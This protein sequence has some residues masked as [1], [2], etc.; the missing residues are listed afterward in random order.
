MI[1]S[2]SSS[3]S[4]KDFER[5]HGT[6]ESIDTTTRLNQSPPTV[7]TPNRTTTTTIDTTNDD[8]F[9]TLNQT[10]FVPSKFSPS[11]NHYPSLGTIHHHN[12]HD[13]IDDDMTELDHDDY[14]MSRRMEDNEDD[15][16][17]NSSNNRVVTL[18]CGRITLPLWCTNE[19]S[20][21][22]IAHWV[23]QHAPCFWCSST[24]LCH[25]QQHHGC[26]G[27]D[28]AATSTNR[29]ILLRMNILCAVFALVQM[30]CAIWLSIVLYANGIVQR[31]SPYGSQ[32][33][34]D[35]VTPDLWNSNV[36]LFLLGFVSVAVFFTM[37]FTIPVV[38]E[39]NL[40]GAIRY[41]WTLVWILPLE[42]FFVIGLFDYRHVMNVWITHW[43]RVPSMAYFR[44]AFC[45][46]NTFNTKCLVPEGGDGDAMLQSEI[47]WCQYHFNASDCT[48]IR[49]EAQADM[50]N[51]YSVFFNL[52]GVWGLLLII[53]LYLTIA[54]L[55]EIITKPVV[56][57]SRESN[58]PLWLSVPT[59]GC[60]TVGCILL[61]SPSSVF[62]IASNSS[63]AWIGVVYLICGITFLISALLGWFISSFSILNSR[64]KKYKI[65]AVVLFIG[66]MMTTIILIGTIFCVSILWSVDLVN[67]S[68]TDTQRGDL[69]CSIDAV[70]SCTQCDNSNELP[71]CPEWSLEDVVKV[72]QTQLKE[73]ATL[74][75]IVFLYS[76]G[77]VRFGLV[78]LKHIMGYQIEYV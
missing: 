39:V 76:L 38:R 18:F 42:A 75:A 36:T 72:L 15:H 27:G 45:A 28:A 19:P 44:Y 70:N 40:T 13:I 22:R 17:T 34:S 71:K 29:S 69:A 7:R 50:F 62:Q 30:T 73:S 24:I 68:L 6:D 8:S 26:G 2:S 74:A 51:F 78:L 41:M 49:E 31:D 20:W 5:P 35:K 46:N 65:G 55:E 9:S 25:D 77:S 1:S 33:Q 23:V 16:S 14:P 67:F 59:L 54:V 53:L 66:L 43:W 61:Y 4:S 11:N 47:A 64:D 37:I 58:V 32:R 60:L 52:N 21:N 3:S 56:Q 63:S 57:A 12:H 10:S 48:M